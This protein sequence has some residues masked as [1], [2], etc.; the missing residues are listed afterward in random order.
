MVVLCLTTHGRGW[1]EVAPNVQEEQDY[2]SW[3]VIAFAVLSFCA[4]ASNAC[5]Y[6]AIYRNDR[7]TRACHGD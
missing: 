2:I 4:R 5:F 7:V 3:C 1:G 6:V